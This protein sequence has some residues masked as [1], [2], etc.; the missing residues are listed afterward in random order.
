[1]PLKMRL[2]GWLTSLG[3]LFYG[4]PGLIAATPDAVKRAFRQGGDCVAVGCANTPAQNEVEGATARTNAAERSG[5]GP[6]ATG[7]RARQ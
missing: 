5:A 4:M 7:K 1:M 6:V 2:V 3:T